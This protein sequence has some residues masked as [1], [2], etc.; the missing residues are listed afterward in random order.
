MADA[1]TEPL[2][3]YA[4]KNQ[5]AFVTINRPQQRNAMS[6]AVITE[7]LS[8]FAKAHDDN[9][10]RCIILTG[11]G[12][13]AF[14]AGGD[15]TSLTA[16]VP[17]MAAHEGRRLYATLIK[18]LQEGPKPTV[19][20]VNGHALAGGL[21]VVMAC[22]L[23]VSVDEASFGLPEVEVGLFPMMVSALLQ[24]SVGRKRALELLMTARTLPATEAL[25]W[26]LINRV[27]YRN[28][29][30]A[31]VDEL[32]G[33]LVSKSR[34]VLAL[35][36]RA[37]FQSEDLALAPALEFLAAQLSLNSQLDDAREGVQ[38]FLNKRKPEWTDK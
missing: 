22:D 20:R 7:L 10:V 33:K 38:A 17:G 23:A 5:R 1:A 14:S 31:A 34:A 32:S 13:K 29:L 37:Y 15:L 24:R 12:E 18:A 19:A 4:V 3:L 26:G 9:E 11:A 27:V 25:S 6:A 30:D 21:G 35:G 8:A 16:P 36:R 28:D 2:V